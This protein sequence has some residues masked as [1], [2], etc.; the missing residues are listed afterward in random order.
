MDANVASAAQENHRSF[1]PSRGPD[2]CQPVLAPFLSAG[3][4]AFG[5]TYAV[6]YV[7]FCRLPDYFKHTLL[8]SD[9]MLPISIFADC[10]DHGGSLLE[11]TYPVAHFLFP[12]VILAGAC[13][14]VT[15]EIGRSVLLHAGVNLAL[16]A[17]GVR[18]CLV[19]HDTKCAPVVTDCCWLCAVAFLIFVMFRAPG[20]YLMN[21]CYHAGIYLVSLFSL[22]LVIRYL[23]R[24]ASDIA[25][26]ELA[27]FSLLCFL[28]GISDPL[29]VPYFVAPLVATLALM[30]ALARVGWM[31][32]GVL[33]ASSMG[34]TLAGLA[35]G[36]ALFNSRAAGDLLHPTLTKLFTGTWF[37]CNSFL[38]NAIAGDAHHLL[39]IAWVTVACLVAGV[40]LRGERA[41][42]RGGQSAW[43]G[44]DASQQVVL[45]RVA[46]CLVWL[47]LAPLATAA[48]VVVGGSVAL[49]NDYA[50]LQHYFVPLWYGHLFLVP[51]LVAIIATRSPGAACLVGRT[52][53]LVGFSIAVIMAVG[54]IRFAPSASLLH[55]YY[56]LFVQELDRMAKEE[57]IQQGIAGYWNAGL[58]NAFSHEGVRALPVSINDGVLTYFAFNVN[59]YHL[60]RF[61]C[62]GDPNRDIDFAVTHLDGG[63]C[64]RD[65]YLRRFGPPTRERRIDSPALKRSILTYDGPGRAGFAN[66][67]VKVPTRI[68]MLWKTD[69]TAQSN[70]MVSWSGALLPG[71][72]GRVEGESRVARQEL[73]TPPGCLSYGPYLELPPGDYVASLRYATAH[74]DDLDS[75]GQCD[76]FFSSAGQRWVGELP[77]ARET[78]GTFRVH[79][80]VPKGG[81]GKFQ[82]RV[83]YAGKA[84]VEVRELSI[85]SRP[86]SDDGVIR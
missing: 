2:W 50:Y 43:S 25:T 49:E 74:D 68:G 51:A 64:D 77:P 45:A 9:S 35:L 3:F 61:V 53:R 44:D 58:I 33:T 4:L 22:G 37:L 6:F 65:E 82:F 47:A 12:D 55:P 48:A 27:A 36:E 21:P 20:T 31:R 11:W 39:G 8:N 52:V 75:V 15:G 76:V 41:G 14:L 42:E 85:A 13:Y 7:W 71:L 5:A 78:G 86:S 60:V 24:D 29:F 16:F 19:D 17:L 83:H 79:F 66:A 46:F 30:A 67:L 32:V 59:P 62:P 56:P 38:A 1:R 23:R 28:A 57:G 63:W 69:P 84:D 72:V 40:L 73:A 54:A 26:W 34:C 81:M 10:W 18:F 80:T 70:R